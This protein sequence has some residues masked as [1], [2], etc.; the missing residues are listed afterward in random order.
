M[1][2]FLFLA[3]FALAPAPPPHTL[4][5]MK[6]DRETVLKAC[7]AEFGSAIDGKNNLFEVSRYYLLEAKFDNGGRLTQLGVLPKHWFA[8]G[9]PEWAQARDVGE[10]RLDEYKAL[11]R[12]LERIRPK[13]RLQQRA[14]WPIVTGTVATR[15][16]TYSS[17]VLAT[18]DV[19]LSDMVVYPK[20][21]RTIKYFVVYFTTT[22]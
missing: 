1:L 4:A 14:R 5:S 20:R 19:S 8:D 21:P 16:D 10:L 3:L 6:A 13:G 17:A 11:V 18:S 2:A 7:A 15:R 12:R 22:K 9:H